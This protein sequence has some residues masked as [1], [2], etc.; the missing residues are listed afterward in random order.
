MRRCRP[1]QHQSR[2][3]D[4][5][6]TELVADFAAMCGTHGWRMVVVGCGERRLK[7]W[8]DTAIIAPQ[9]DRWF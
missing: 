5:H 4:Q 8:S 2:P 1:H 3:G 7:L 9:G 6:F